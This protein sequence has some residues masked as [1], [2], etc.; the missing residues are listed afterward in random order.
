M[1]PKFVAKALGFLVDGIVTDWNKDERKIVFFIPRPA[2]SPVLSL[3]TKNAIISTVSHNLFI[4][5]VIFL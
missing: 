2:N 3:E 1:S 4:P 5:A